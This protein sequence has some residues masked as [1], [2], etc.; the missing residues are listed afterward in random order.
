M[1]AP[2]LFFL[3][4]RAPRVISLL[5]FLFFPSSAFPRRPAARPLAVAPPRRTLGS[6]LSHSRGPTGH[7]RALFLLLEAP[8]HLGRAEP[9]RTAE[10]TGCVAVIRTPRTFFPPSLARPLSLAFLS[11]AS[12][13]STSPLCPSAAAPLHD[14]RAAPPPCATAIQHRSLDPRPPTAVAVPRRGKKRAVPL[15]F[16]FPLCMCAP[17]LPP[18][19][20]AAPVVE[21]P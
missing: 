4:H 3:C 15:S 6:P 5:P 10:G 16:P 20:R 1:C 17:H 14:P 21:T 11:A 19:P 18:L 2:P 7:H 13:P 9:Q 8:Q 12:T